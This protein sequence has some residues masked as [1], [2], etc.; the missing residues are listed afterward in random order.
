MGGM[1]RRRRI[2]PAFGAVFIL[3]GGV[4]L[5]GMVL[6]RAASDS[7]VHP[8]I[9]GCEGVPEAVA[10]SERLILRADR[11]ERYLAEL[12][13]KRAEIAEAEAR[14]TARLKELRAVSTSPAAR[15]TGQ[16]QAVD[17]DIRRMVAIYDVMKPADAAGVMAHLPP[18]YAA[19]ILMRVG[20]E[21]G[22]RIVGAMDSETAAVVT[23]HMGARSAR[24]N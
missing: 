2:L 23:A 4:Q 16:A 19:E 15:Q 20:P 10:L 21:N 18:A 24:Q 17:E 11:V 22:A 6:A 5:G 7:A 1:M 9:A 14:L 8:L 13:R 12:D 3:A